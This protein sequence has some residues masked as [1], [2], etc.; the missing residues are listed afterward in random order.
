M[1][2]IEIK[3]KGQTIVYMEAHGKKLKVG[4]MI[5]KTQ[6]ETGKTSLSK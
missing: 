3:V 5:W 4:E 6:P 2:K 1:L